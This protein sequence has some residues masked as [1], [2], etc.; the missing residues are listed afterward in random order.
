M[1]DH[2]KPLNNLLAGVH[3]NC[4]ILIE[5]LYIVIVVVGITKVFSF[6]GQ[7][8]IC[9]FVHQVKLDSAAFG[10][11]AMPMVV[12]AGG[13]FSRLKIQFRIILAD[14]RAVYV[15]KTSSALLSARLQQGPLTGRGTYL[16]V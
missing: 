2:F 9:I 13:P 15:K 11:P 1:D 6:D 5:S 12:V 4:A 14:A 10:T 7:D 16:F 3:L 8:S